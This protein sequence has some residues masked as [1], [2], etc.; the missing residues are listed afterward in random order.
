MVCLHLTENGKEEYEN[1]VLYQFPEF[2]GNTG[3][4]IDKVKAVAFKDL[5][6]DGRTDIVIL[7][8]NTP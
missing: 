7:A 2:Y 4:M 5:N 8:E 3:R 1:K 6:V